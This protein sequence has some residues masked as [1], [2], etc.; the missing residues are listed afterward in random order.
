[1]MDAVNTTQAVAVFPGP[2]TDLKSR[3]KTRNRKKGWT[4][5][6]VTVLVLAAAGLTA[7]G[8]TRKSPKTT[9]TVPNVIGMT[10]AKA[11]STLDMEGL[12]VGAVTTVASD[13]PIN[14]VVATNPG[15]G[16]PISKGGKVDLS[17][18][19]GKGAVQVVVPNVTGQ[20]LQA[21]ENTLQ[22]AG[23][24]V[25]VVTTTSSSASPNTVLS[26]SPG[27]NSKVAK[28]SII[29]LTVVASPAYTT[30]P[31]LVGQ[32]ASVI[33]AT[34]TSNN[35]QIGSQSTACDNTQPNGSVVSQSPAA[36][37]Q[38][39]PST[40][41]SVVVSSGP[42]QVSVPLVTGIPLS[43]AS[44][45]L[46]AAGFNVAPDSSCS[47]PSFIVATQTPAADN[48]ATFGSTIQLTC[49]PAPSSTDTPT[50]AD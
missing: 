5:A 34:L 29:T 3:R 28:G 12:Q 22:T 16:L 25:K 42:C 19:D 4:I 48:S 15:V 49:N 43:Q 23:F 9:L 17:L 8:V 47:D 32:S 7:Y 40:S 14:Q 35:L 2:K 31:N 20:Q 1:M 30:V 27:P 50:P 26:Q 18:S 11:L 6:M 38:V 36:G 45:T 13:K 46:K 39:S 24:T 37:A 41:V 21:A 33:G 44:Q 10:Q